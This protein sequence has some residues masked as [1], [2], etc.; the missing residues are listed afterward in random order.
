[1]KLCAHTNSIAPLQVTDQLKLLKKHDFE[2]VMVF[3]YPDTY[4]NSPDD[5]VKEANKLDLRVE[6]VHIPFFGAEHLS[7][8]NA[9]SKEVEDMVI[10]TLKKCHQHQVKKAVIHASAWKQ[11]TKEDGII[12]DRFKR[13][14]D[15]AERYDIQLGIENITDVKV[16]DYIYENIKSNHLGF[17]FDNGHHNIFHPREN[18]LY[19]YKDK[20][21]GLHLTDNDGVDDHHELPFNGNYN[22]K[23]FMDQLRLVKYEGP[24]SFEVGWQTGHQEM[25]YT[26][27]EYVIELKTRAE[28]LIRL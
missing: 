7:R 26:H 1:M 22:W 10:N 24:L 2:S 5:M 25:K 21:M 28:K 6:N 15:L 27:E 17:C 16:I 23:Q 9:D 3:W 14:I 4:G 8:N 18:L 12:I 19:K 20:L 13:F 11:A